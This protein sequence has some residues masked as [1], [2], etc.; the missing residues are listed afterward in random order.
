MTALPRRCSLVVL[1]LAC[2]VAPLSGCASD[3]V[4]S[5]TMRVEPGASISDVVKSARPG[6]I[7]VIADGTYFETVR[8]AVPGITLR[9]ESRNGVVLDGEDRLANGITVVADNVAVENLTVHS[10][11]Q[12]G[13]LF[14]GI[15]AASDGQ[16]ADPN[17][18]Y[19]TGD[20]V[21]KG[22]RA[23]Y[24]TAYNNG[25]YG[26]YAFASRDGLI[27]HSYV[28]GH[29]DSGV[30]VGQ[31]NPCNTVVRDVIAER[32]AIGYYGTNASGEVY[33]IESTFRHNR[34]GIAPNSQ[35]AERLA[36][37]TSTVVAGNLVV[38]NDAVDAPPI[39]Q[40]F[41][42]VGI[43]VGGGT[44]NIV[45]RNRVEGNDVAGIALTTLGEFEPLSNRV[46]GNVVLRNG[47]DLLYAPGTTDVAG[48]CFAGNTFET[49]MPAGIEQSM[50]C[51]QTGDVPLVSWSQPEPPPGPDYRDV[52]A[53]GPQDE[54]PSAA[55]S[56]T[57]G[58]GAPPSIDVDAITIP[59][60]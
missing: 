58:A 50:A 46:E 18:V 2:G 8:I 1:G 9:G 47:T 13:L 15:E 7:V 30:Y 26:I 48:N 11:T 29:P 36:P 51:G 43:A 16:G 23:S 53:P 10:F 49:S 14:N 4:G 20:D 56:T 27:E 37:Q 19:G 44:E 57:G 39:P 59:P 24:V 21:L 3:D 17:V 40:G 6:D 60:A 33:V 35:K 38:D 12:N 55:M 25:L 42:G 52:P 22:Y 34:L 31:C 5:R 41:I 54:M 28:S 32:N 45:V